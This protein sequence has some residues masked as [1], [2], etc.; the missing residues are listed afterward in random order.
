M[1]SSLNSNEIATLSLLQSRGFGGGSGGYGYG[2]GGGMGGYGGGNVVG[3]SVL[4]ADAHANGT[5]TNA[6]ADCNA[7]RFSD[8]LGSLSDQFENVARTAQFDR[9]NENISDQEFRTAAALTSLN[10]DITDQEF[11][12]IDRQ[13]DI[14]RTLGENAKEA[15]ACCCET[16]KLILAEGNETRALVLAVESRANVASLAAAQAKITQLETINALSRHHG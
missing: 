12:G 3:N 6:K 13:R 8:G 14:E 10:K 16:Q 1:D 5:A 2:V 11:R 15:A 4:A 9:L 7:Q